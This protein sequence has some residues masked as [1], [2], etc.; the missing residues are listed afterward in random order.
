MFK[1]LYFEAPNQVPAEKI[2]EQGEVDYQTKV[3]W[4]YDQPN[5]IDKRKH[6]RFGKYYETE[7][8]CRLYVDYQSYKEIFNF[9]DNC[10]LVEDLDNGLGLYL[11][12]T[13]KDENVIVF[14]VREILELPDIREVNRFFNGKYEIEFNSIHAVREPSMPNFV[15]YGYGNY[16]DNSYGY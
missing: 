13:D 7:I 2:V 5:P 9:I 4:I 16:G 14:P 3:A 15:N 1:L 6:I 8:L 12:I 10:N 11:W